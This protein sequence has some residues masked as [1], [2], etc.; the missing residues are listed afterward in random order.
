[1]AI[2]LQALARAAEGDPS[3]KVAVSRRWL[4]EVHRQLAR[5]DLN[6]RLDDIGERLFSLSSNACAFPQ[7][8]GEACSNQAASKPV[9][10]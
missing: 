6:G 10:R 2:D 7:T 1:M 4:A 9:R 3:S 8:R 5:N